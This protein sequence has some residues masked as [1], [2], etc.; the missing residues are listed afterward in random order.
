MLFFGCSAKIIARGFKIA[1]DRAAIQNF[2]LSQGKSH[3]FRPF[4]PG[5]VQFG[6][7]KAV[8]ALKWTIA[9]VSYGGVTRL[10]RINPGVEAF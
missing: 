7:S 3:V 2:S 9:R 8:G 6:E 10:V 1:R 5:L 4:E